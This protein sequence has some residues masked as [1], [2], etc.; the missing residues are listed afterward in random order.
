MQLGELMPSSFNFCV[1]FS[2]SGCVYISAKLATALLQIL[3]SVLLQF[4]RWFCSNSRLPSFRL[5][6]FLPTQV[7]EMV[8][9]LEREQDEDDAHYSYCQDELSM[10]ASR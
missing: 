2:P 6:Y 4:S 3:K 1:Y 10:K 8:S 7:Q 5:D 9:N